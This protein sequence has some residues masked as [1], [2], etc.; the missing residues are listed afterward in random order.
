[1]IID[2]IDYDKIKKI[3]NKQHSLSLKTLEINKKHKLLD[4]DKEELRQIIRRY[5]YEPNDFRKERGK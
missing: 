3:L 5:N 4:I 2:N 1:M